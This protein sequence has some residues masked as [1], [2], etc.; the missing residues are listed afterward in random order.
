MHKRFWTTKE[1][2]ILREHYPKDGPEFCLGL[3]P[4]RTLYA[5]YGH[6]GLL[7]LRHKRYSASP[8]KRWETDEHI[9]RAIIDCYRNN[10]QKNA[11]RELAERIRRPRWWVLKRATALGLKTPRLKEPPWSE[12]EKELLEKCAHKSPEAIWKIFRRHGF[13]R[14]ETA[15]VMKRKRLRCDT[16]DIDHYTCRQLAREFGVDDKVV[17]GWINKGWLKAGKRGTKRLS[18][19]GG[20]MWWIRRKDIKSF[21]AE[22]AS[23]IDLRKV[24]KIWFIDLL[25]N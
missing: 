1:E 8:R 18:R 17:A 11:V 23:Q 24:D 7:G 6:A 10:P 9:D 19:Q 12:A 13:Q 16:V 21:V 22:N 15:I 14:T 3:L 2:R 4:G 25:T 20:D 5:I